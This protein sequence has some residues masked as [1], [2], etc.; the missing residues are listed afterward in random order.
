MAEDD[1]PEI[2]VRRESTALSFLKQRD[3]VILVMML[4][5]VLAA[6]SHLATIRLLTEPSEEPRP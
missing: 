1:G 3:Q 5:I 4:C 2:V 6:I